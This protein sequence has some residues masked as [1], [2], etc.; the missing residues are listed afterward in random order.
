[1]SAAIHEFDLDGQP[2][3]VAETDAQWHDICALDF[4]IRER[5]VAALL[6]QIQI[7]VFRTYDDSLYAVGNIDPF[8]GAAVLSRGIVGSRGTVATVASPLHKQVFSLETG[9]CLDAPEVWLP[10]Y[11]ARVVD[12]R[13]E[14]A[15]Q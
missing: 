7:A 11:D 2:N 12:G 6:G 3:S 9:Q 5:G 13:V 10:R 8:S 15:V 14:V 4:L 1:M